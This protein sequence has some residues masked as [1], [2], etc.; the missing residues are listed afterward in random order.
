MRAVLL[1]HGCMLERAVQIFAYTGVQFRFAQLLYRF[2][3]DLLIA[4]FSS[5]L[6][7]MVL[8]SFPRKE[9]EL[10]RT[11]ETRL[12]QLDVVVPFSWAAST[13]LNV[14]QRRAGR[15]ASESKW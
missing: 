11:Q 10:G 5:Q 9:R 4:V 3:S 6:I 12:P 2:G 1:P 14:A 8:L 15:K 13:Q 7:W